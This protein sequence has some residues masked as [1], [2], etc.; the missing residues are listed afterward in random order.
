MYVPYDALGDFAGPVAR[1]PAHELEIVLV[2]NPWKAA[3]RPYHKAKLAL[4]LASQRA[5]A[6]EQAKRGALVTPLVARDGPYRTAL[7]PLARAR[8]G[9]A[10]VQPGERELRDDLA[11]LAAAG[12]LCPEPGEA[13]TD[14]ADL[15]H[16][17]PHGPPWRMDAFY[18]TVRRRTGVLMDGDRPVGGRFSF[19]GENRRPWRGTPPA[20]APPSFVH[21]DI[22]DEVFELVRTTFARHP[23]ALDPAAL[24]VRADQVEAA[25]AWALNRALPWFGPFED[26]MAARAPTL[27]HTRIS[28]LLNLG[29]LSARRVVR[30]A[31][32]APVDLP[33]KEGFVRQVLGWREF[34]RRVHDATDGF[35]T[36]AP[37]AA[38][39]GDGGWERAYGAPW[40]PSAGLGP[41]DDPDGGALPNA[42]N[43]H[44]PL[45][46]AFWGRTSGLN[47][48]D[49][50][51]A[52]VWATGWGHHIT[53]LM[54]LANVAQ[55][56]D[57]TPREL[58][59]WFWAAYIDAFDWVVEPN[60]LGMGTFAAGDVMTTKPYVSGAAYIHKMS[61]YCA[62]CRF[63]PARTCPLTPMYW[64]YLQ[65]HADALN[66][67]P[68]MGVVMRAA[69]AR[70]AAQ[71][72]HDRAVYESAR[73]AL[74][75]GR[76]L[77]AGEARPTA[78]TRRP[79]RRT[80]AC[81][82]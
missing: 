8:G 73:A 72:E 16:A 1:I 82:A 35:R 40:R 21:D 34:V 15:H 69:A 12:L 63:D 27:F 28:A 80:G 61:D 26:A 50:V 57:V 60:V 51:V 9:I 44:T 59:D 66:A 48:L 11:P 17:H 36:L 62:G 22:A 47:C 41:A 56:L 70:S 32:A 54:V 43:M 7:E 53:R 37:A 10:M 74:S 78:P 75:A 58:T 14:A 2:E 45:P 20:P 81:S 55:L 33:S 6:L 49:S 76:E 71:R 65:R 42:L 18:R 25:W 38:A 30:E 13:L 3:R 79:T 4:V 39:P 24:P 31:A 64:A 68:R 29:R 23:G 46:A 52:D 77:P 67:N 19:D 5:F